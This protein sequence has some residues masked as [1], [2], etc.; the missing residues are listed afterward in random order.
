MLQN[1]GIDLS[2]LPSVL[3]NINGE[4]KSMPELFVP[5]KKIIQNNLNLLDYIFSL[6]LFDKRDFIIVFI[7]STIFGF[8]GSYFISKKINKTLIYKI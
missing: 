8:I 1:I 3:Q 2:L 6:I 5:R 4:T 7:L